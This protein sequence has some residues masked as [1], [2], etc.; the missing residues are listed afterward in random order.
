MV[1]RKPIFILVYGSIFGFVCFLTTNLW[2]SGIKHR[3]FTVESLALDL[4]S[5][6]I[7][8]L[9]VGTT[10]WLLA[11]WLARQNEPQAK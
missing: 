1:Q 4:L 9:V 3:P 6:L 5:W 7:A 10:Q 11:S 8:G 2:K